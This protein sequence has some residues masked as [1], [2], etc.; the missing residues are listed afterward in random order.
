VEIEGEV[1]TV[2]IALAELVLPQRVKATQ[3]YRYVFIPAVAP[4]IFK[5]AVVVLE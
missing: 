4:A 1:F 3:R 5:V 2:S